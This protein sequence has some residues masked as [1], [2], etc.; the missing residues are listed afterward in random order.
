MEMITPMNSFSLLTH[1]WYNHKTWNCIA[2]NIAK[3]KLQQRASALQLAYSLFNFLRINFLLM[4]RV[5]NPPCS[6]AE[7]KLDSSSH[8]KTLRILARC[9]PHAF[10]ELPKSNLNRLQA[11]SSLCRSEILPK[12]LDM[13]ITCKSATFFSSLNS[14]IAP[15]KASFPKSKKNGRWRA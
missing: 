12:E 10:A 2:L 15:L 4:L 14:L 6:L 9:D 8:R 3:V 1:R 13:E 7:W 11:Y 5:L